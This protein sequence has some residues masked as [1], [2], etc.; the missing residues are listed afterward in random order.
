MKLKLLLSVS[1]LSFTFHFLLLY[2]HLVPNNT[3]NALRRFIE[4]LFITHAETKLNTL[5][6][7]DA[8][9]STI[10]I[11]STDKLCYENLVRP[12]T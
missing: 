6:H 5:G 1:R 4:A 2:Y 3:S 8:D 10:H 7:L 11:E 12:K 9:H